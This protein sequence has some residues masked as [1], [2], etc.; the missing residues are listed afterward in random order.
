MYGD[1]ERS[2]L[3]IRT[4]QQSNHYAR[5]E[6]LY[7]LKLTRCPPSLQRAPLPSFRV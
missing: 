6:F 7:E 3:A 4:V 1:A 5:E 2:M